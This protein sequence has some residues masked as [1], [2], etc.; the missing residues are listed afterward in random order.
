MPSAVVTEVVTLL[1]T[2]GELAVEVLHEAQEKA[3]P[4]T[5]YDV[6]AAALDDGVGVGGTETDALDEGEV[7]GVTL[8][9]VVGET[10][11]DRLGDTDTDCITLGEADADRVTLGDTVGDTDVDGVTLGEADADCV[12]L[13]DTDT[14]TLCVAEVDTVGVTLKPG[15]GETEGETEGDTLVDGVTLG[16]AAT[17]GVTL[18]DADGVALGDGGKSPIE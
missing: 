5:M 10:E 13:G 2:L 15:V 17:D 1:S 4:T 8:R 18:G 3:D 7:E 11:G 14:E 16:D 6:P 9:P 12:T